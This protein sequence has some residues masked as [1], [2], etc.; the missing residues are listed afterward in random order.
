M[1]V[2]AHAIR[3]IVAADRSIQQALAITDPHINPT[4]IYGWT[5]VSELFDRLCF[6]VCETVLRLPLIPNTGKHLDDAELTIKDHLYVAFNRY[7][8]SCGWMFFVSPNIQGWLS[9]KWD[10]F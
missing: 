10:A 1:Y 8:A 3:R 7:V 9:A 4:S 5:P 6:F 2:G